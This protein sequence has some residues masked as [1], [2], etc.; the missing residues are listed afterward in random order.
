M[1]N[2]NCT[3]SGLVVITKCRCHRRGFGEATAWHDDDAVTFCPYRGSRRQLAVVFVLLGIFVFSLV[4][5]F[6]S[7]FMPPPYGGTLE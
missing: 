3:S 2:A 4:L 7:V 1:R 5:L 6:F